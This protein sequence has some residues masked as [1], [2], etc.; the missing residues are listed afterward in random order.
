MKTNKGKAPQE[1]ELRCPKCGKT[2]KGKM[3]D[4]CPNCGPK[5]KEEKK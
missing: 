3:T 4:P 1:Y 5:K 2:Y